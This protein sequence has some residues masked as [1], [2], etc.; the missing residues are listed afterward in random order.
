MELMVNGA[1]PDSSTSALTWSKLVWRAKTAKGTALRG[2]NCILFCYG[3]K[4]A[5]SRY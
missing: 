5:T 1:Y 4:I 2:L 3:A